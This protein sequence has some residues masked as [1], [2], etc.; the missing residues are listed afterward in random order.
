[1]R[2]PFKSALIGLLAIALASGP[3]TASSQAG[4]SH[5]RGAGLGLKS[6]ASIA[7]I[8]TDLTFGGEAAHVWRTRASDYALYGGARETLRPGPA[9]AESYG[10][11]VYPLAG[12]WG[13]SLEAGYVPESM[14]APQR[15][16]LAGQLHTAFAGG[17]VSIGLKYRAYGSDM[18]GRSTPLES[19]SVNSYTLAPSLLGNVPASYQVQMSYQYSAS[20]TFG[21]AM[22]REVETF[23]PLTD[24]ALAGQRQFSI[25]GQHWLTPSW[26]LSYDVLSND[27]M[28]P[29]R[30]QGLRLGMRYRF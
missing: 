29:L 26:A 25:T 11:I 30:V 14:L 8:P 4:L 10:G 20:G 12:N 27:V 24:P 21:L 15:Y 3:D 13:T 23:T 22:G 18:T 2:P 6:P 9:G 16:T 5:E 7:S 28:T 17:G 19:T 1:M